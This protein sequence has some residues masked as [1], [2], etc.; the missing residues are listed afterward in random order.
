MIKD[1]KATTWDWGLLIT[2]CAVASVF[3]GTPLIKLDVG[4]FQLY[5]LRLFGFVGFF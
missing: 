3:F 4:F 5:P 2:Y 1:S